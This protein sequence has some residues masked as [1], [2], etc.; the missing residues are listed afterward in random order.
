MD[1]VSCDFFWKLPFEYL[2]AK[3]RIFFN[4]DLSNGSFSKLVLFSLKW[5]E[6]F[7][8]RL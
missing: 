1:P 4:E 8:E 6:C 2:Q 3:S 7:R 5:F